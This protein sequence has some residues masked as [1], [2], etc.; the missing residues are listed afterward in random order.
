M[1]VAARGVELGLAR[2][3]PLGPDVLR[4]ARS[5]PRVVPEAVQEDAEN[6]DPAPEQLVPG[7]D[8]LV[9]R[10]HAGANAEDRPV[11]EVG[12]QDGVGDREN[13]RTV[14]DDVVECS[15]GVGQEALH[16][17]RVEKSGRIRSERPGG[18]NGHVRNLRSTGSPHRGP[19]GP[20]EP[21]RGRPG[22]RRS[23]PRGCE[24]DAGRR[25][26]EARAGPAV[27]G[28]SRGSW[29]SRS[30]LR[31]AR[32]TSRRGT[33][34]HRHETEGETSGRRGTPRRRWT[35]EGRGE[36]A[37]SGSS[38]SVSRPAVSRG[39]DSVGCLEYP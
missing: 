33:S 2:L 12:D 36:A 3:L 16:R 31:A 23:A 37:R 20:R 6:G 14:E 5:R 4:S 34:R 25:R 13:G 27:R 17:L 29:R 21:T 38:S 11:G 24:G 39:P 7:P 19:C 18:K 22:W 8:D 15:G 28:R 35:A 32:P 10:R 9:S 26:R 30:C 1:V